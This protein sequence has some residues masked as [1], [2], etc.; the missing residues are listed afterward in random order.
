MPGGLLREAVD[1]RQPEPA[2]RSDVLRGE[3]RLERPLLDLLR[4][5]A[6]GV[7]HG[8]HN[9]APGASLGVQTHVIEVE[10]RILRRDAQFSSAGH[11]VAGID[12]QVENGVLQLARVDLGPP[13][14][15]IRFGLDLNGLAERAPKDRGHLR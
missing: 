15:G 10:L 2:P 8:D 4:H 9:I 14:I 11:R 13:E 6:P 5:T 12:G 1:H 7:G 3:E